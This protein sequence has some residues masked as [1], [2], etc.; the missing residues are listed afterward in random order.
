M[1]FVS[2]SHALFFDLN[3]YEVTVYLP[4]IINDLNDSMLNHKTFTYSKFPII[5]YLELS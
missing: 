4:H 5:L 2:L 3:N 1:P